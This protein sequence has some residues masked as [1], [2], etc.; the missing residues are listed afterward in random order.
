[1][2]DDETRLEDELWKLCN[3]LRPKMEAAEYKHV[4]LRIYSLYAL[5]DI[6]HNKPKRDV[7]MPDGTLWENVYENVIKKS[8][9]EA[10]LEKSEDDEDLYVTGKYLDGIMKKIADQNDRIRGCFPPVFTRLRVD[11]GTLKSLMAG[12]NNSFANKDPGLIYQFLLKK[13]AEAEGRG[14]GEF[15]TPE[16][17]LDLMVR[18]LDFGE[19]DVIYEPCFGAGSMIVACHKHAMKKSNTDN[20]VIQFYG[21]EANATNYQIGKVHLFLEGIEADLRLG[22]TL[23]QDAFKDNPRAT[24]AI[25]NPPFN[26]KNWAEP[27]LL[28]ID[29]DGN[30]LDNRWSWGM[31]PEGNA[32]F[33]WMQLIN[34]QVAEGEK[35]SNGVVFSNGTL[36]NRDADSIRKKMVGEA[37]PGLIITLPTKLFTNTPIPSVIWFNRGKSELRKNQTLF[38]DCRRKGRMKKGSR[39]QSELLDEEIDEI[40]DV[41]E[42]WTGKKEGKYTDIPGF[43]KS[44]TI[45][46]I[47]MKEFLMTPGRYAGPPPL[48]EDDEPFE[49]KM[50]RLLGQI[51]RHFTTSDELEKQIRESIGGMGFEFE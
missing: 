40:V 9:E 17:I 24:G 46:E 28:A 35:K 51:S 21:Q 16:C 15:F 2:A 50:E 3:K 22:D 30:P 25:A 27:R 11:G 47:E 37:V 18:I 12:F 14:G 48:P 8:E 7:K 38:I 13:F 33:A 23:N 10:N 32:N 41:W 36:T 26:L 29:E 42:I 6:Y 4:I 44:A 19:D 1:M 43:C 49:E 39:V 5:T 34:H 20:Q 31:P 45:S